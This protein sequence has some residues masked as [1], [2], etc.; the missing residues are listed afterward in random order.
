[1]HVR[2]SGQEFFNSI[3]CKADDWER[4]ADSLEEAPRSAQI[5]RLLSPI[6][7][8]R[9]LMIHDIANDCNRLRT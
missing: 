5:E 8:I 7:V 1:M 4:A 2:F 9:R 3:G 6:A